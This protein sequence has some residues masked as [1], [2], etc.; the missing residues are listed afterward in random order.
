MTWV[1]YIFTKRREKAASMKIR[2]I[3]LF[4]P[5]LRLIINPIRIVLNDKW[6]VFLHPCLFSCKGVLPTPENPRRDAD[7]MDMLGYYPIQPYENAKQPKVQS[8][9]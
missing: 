2:R 9:G 4:M 7:S 1:R 3:S 6:K 8:K 5:D